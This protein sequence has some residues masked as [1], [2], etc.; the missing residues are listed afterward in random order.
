MTRKVIRYPGQLPTGLTKIGHATKDNTTK[1]QIFLGW[2][3]GKKV[4][5]VDG[6]FGPETRKW[7]VNFQKRVFT[8][9][10]EHDGEVGPKTIA[11]AKTIT[12]AVETEGYTYSGSYPDLTKLSG[13]I[14]ASKAR[15]LAWPYGTKKSTYSYPNGKPT[16]AFK[17]AID[18]VFPSHKKW[19][20]QTGAGASCDVFAGTTIRASGYDVTFPRGLDED[21]TYLPKHKGLWK[22]VNPSK[23]SELKPGDVIFYIKK[24]GG[25]HICIYIGN[26]KICEAG[27]VTKRYGCTVKLPSAYC[28]SKYISSTYSHFGVYRSCGP[29]RK[30]LKKGDVSQQVSK[31]QLYLNWCL[32][33]KLTADGAYGTA[34]EAAVKKFQTDFGLKVDGI[35]GEKCL[36]KAKTVKR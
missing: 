17:S 23:P 32:G 36:A 27:Y 15:E 26:N 24:K 25:G 33:M 14:I 18:K 35:F 11:K 34:T 5:K 13:D 7:T 12:K 2:Y 22:K 21:K 9:P 8:D 19:G 6:E 28:N 16:A 1:W 29:A 10:K 4:V 30:Y 20:A 3:F 31:L